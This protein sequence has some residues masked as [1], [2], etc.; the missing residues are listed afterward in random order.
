MEEI[1]K[2]KYN[3]KGI[4]FPVKVQTNECRIHE[5]I[6]STRIIVMYKEGGNRPFM[7]DGGCWFSEREI[8]FEKYNNID[9][10]KS[11]NNNFENVVRPVL[12]YLCDNHHPHTTIVITPTTAELLEAVKSIGIVDDYVRD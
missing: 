4:Q 12:K 5:T 9:A 2:L 7:D 11:I 10:R 3:F 1:K 8:D 6:Q